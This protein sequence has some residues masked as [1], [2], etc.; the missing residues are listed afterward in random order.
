MISTAIFATM[1][2]D[3]CCCCGPSRR[4]RSSGFT[5]DDY[6]LTEEGR[7]GYTNIVF[8]SEDWTGKT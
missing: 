8:R 7:W 2:K 5:E 6:A 4:R 3:C 1:N